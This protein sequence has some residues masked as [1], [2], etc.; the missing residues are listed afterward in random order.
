MYLR[1]RVNGYSVE[2]KKNGRRFYKGGFT[3]KKAAT[4]WGNKHQK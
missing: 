4:E 3:S 2:L 1:Q